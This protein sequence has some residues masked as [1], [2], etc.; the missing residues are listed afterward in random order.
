MMMPFA[1]QNRAV[2]REIVFKLNKRGGEGEEEEE[3]A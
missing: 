2:E 3:E 1:A